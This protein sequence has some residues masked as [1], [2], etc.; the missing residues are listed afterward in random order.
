MH[1]AGVHGFDFCIKI[2]ETAWRQVMLSEEQI[3]SLGNLHINR[4][5]LDSR[6]LTV[7]YYEPWSLVTE[8]YILTLRLKHEPPSSTLDSHESWDK[9]L[10]QSYGE[11]GGIAY[12]GRREMEGHT[13]YISFAHEDF[14]EC[15]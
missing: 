3:L 2:S 6:H 5:V 14:M 1:I 12:K 15:Y 7:H 10:L 11:K 8:V 9:V 4:V 13:Q